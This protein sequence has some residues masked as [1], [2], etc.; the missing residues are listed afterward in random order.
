VVAD[1]RAVLVPETAPV[2]GPDS[3]LGP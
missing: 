2:T 1:A 3:L